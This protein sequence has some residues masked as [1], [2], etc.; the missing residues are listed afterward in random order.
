MLP[1]VELIENCGFLVKPR[2]KHVLRLG[3]LLVFSAFCAQ[4]DSD[5]GL[6]TRYYDIAG[7]SAKQLRQEMNRKGPPDESGERFDANTKWWLKWNFW[8]EPGRMG[9]RFTRFELDNQSEIVMPR[10]RDA[11]AASPLLR[12]RWNRYYQALLAHEMQHRTHGVE[13]EREIRQLAAGFRSASGCAAIGDEFNRKAQ[14]IIEK[15]RQADRE[16]DRRTHHGMNEG[17]RFP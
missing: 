4:A 7:T 5:N 15:Y 17:A 11:N 1:R 8:Y 6:S 9:C 2:S 13:A 10:W 12:D 3:L 16:F 14:Q